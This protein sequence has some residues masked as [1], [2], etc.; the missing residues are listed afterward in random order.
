MGF[1]VQ[2]VLAC[3][4]LPVLVPLTFPVV[5]VVMVLD[6]TRWVVLPGS[7]GCLRVVLVVPVYSVSL[8]KSLIPMHWMTPMNSFDLMT[9]R[10]SMTLK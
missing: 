6:L 10:Y 9:M 3:Q 4:A 7:L 1:S 8:M 5:Q 2:M